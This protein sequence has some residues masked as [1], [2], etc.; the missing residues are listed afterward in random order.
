MIEELKKEAKDKDRV[1]II[2]VTPDGSDGVV[3]ACDIEGELYR[4]KI[5]AGKLESLLSVAFRRATD[6]LMKYVNEDKEEN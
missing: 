6:S 3:A 1:M 4:R 5:D 2:I